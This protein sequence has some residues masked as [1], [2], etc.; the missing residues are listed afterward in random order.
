MEPDADGN[1]VTW[2]LVE[3]ADFAGDA[4]AF[5][6]RC[7]AMAGRR[8]VH[9]SVRKTTVLR[10]DDCVAGDVVTI[11]GRD[12]TVTA[13]EDVDGS[14]PAQVA[15]VFDD[16]TEITLPG[17]SHVLAAGERGTS[18]LQVLFFRTE[19]VRA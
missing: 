14:E 12:R 19:Q 1:P 9:A 10:V 2:L 13:V 7:Y 6:N 3:G 15:L 4:E 17:T 16:D 18:A 11:G 5:R 8:G